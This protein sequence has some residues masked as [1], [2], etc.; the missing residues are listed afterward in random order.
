RLRCCSSSR[1][2]LSNPRMSYGTPGGYQT[3]VRGPMTGQ[4]GPGPAQ[5][6]RMM[7]PTGG[8]SVPMG[9]AQAAPNRGPAMY[10]AQQMPMHAGQQMAPRQAY[11]MNNMQVNQ[12]FAQMMQS[13][14]PEIQ[15]QIN[16]EPDQSRKYSLAQYHWQQ[17]TQQQQQ[18]RRMMMQ[19]QQAAGGMPQQMRPIRVPSSSS[20]TASPGMVHSQMSMMQPGTPIQGMGQPIMHHNPP[21]QGSSMQIM[22][23]SPKPVQ[24][25]IDPQSG[26]LQPC[27][28]TSATTSP[29]TQL[30][31]QSPSSQPKTPAQ[32]IAMD[33]FADLQ[34][35]QFPQNSN[36]SS[37]GTNPGS[38]PAPSVVE[39]QMQQYKKK[40]KEMNLKFRD[41]IEKL[42]HKVKGDDGKHPVPPGLERYL[43]IMEEK[44]VVSIDFLDR[45][46]GT[47][48]RFFERSHPMYAL[49][50]AVRFRRTHPELENEPANPT[51]DRWEAVSHLKIQ[52]PEQIQALYPEPRPGFGK[53]LASPRVQAAKRARLSLSQPEF[54]A[55]QQK[56]SA[57]MQ[58]QKPEVFDPI[59][60]EVLMKLPRVIP[61]RFEGA[62]WVIPEMAAQELVNSGLRWKVDQR[63]PCKDTPDVQ[64]VIEGD[65]ILTAPLR[66]LLPHGYPNL[67][68]QVLF[69]ESFPKTSQV[70]VNLENHFRRII[71]LHGCKTLGQ[72]LVGWKAACERY[73]RPP[74]Q[75]GFLNPHQNATKMFA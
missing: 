7:M 61:T 36:P 15:M 68:P 39:A 63:P 41:K 13:F 20:M 50:E 9:A 14:P 16:Q 32:G 40:V 29:A 19:Q 49:H 58:E 46:V 74:S 59:S 38:N 18:R 73:N 57:Q 75:N 64:L 30:V 33:P 52:I 22:S 10:A 67:S 66:I 71:N 6:P 34:M 8:S 43:E 23:V 4:L 3:M 11:Q 12:Q 70:S 47:L 42:I 54:K 55:P 24:Q 26:Q 72:I 48:T 17:L 37:S 45:I 35:P 25:Y 44:R 1:N 62:P 56:E 69:S 21:S 5:Q 65:K 2:Q 51:P 27:Q 60:D 28:P 53:R 31:G